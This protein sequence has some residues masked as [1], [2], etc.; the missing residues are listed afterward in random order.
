MEYL[1]PPEY[2]KTLSVLMSR[3]PQQSMEDVRYV[4]ESEIG[5]PVRFFSIL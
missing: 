2:T 4:I 3:A 5:K 1:I